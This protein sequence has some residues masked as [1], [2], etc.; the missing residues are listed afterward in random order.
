MEKRR[1]EKEKI[2]ISVVI[3]VFNEEG[4]LEELFLRL[5]ETL[6]SIGSIYE[7]IFVD[8]G[9]RDNS[10][11][12]L[13]ELSRKEKAVRV[14]TFRKNFRKSAALA[15]G[16]GKARGKI[17][18]TL[19]ADLQNLPE[20]IPKM[21]ARLEE[22]YD[23]ISGWRINRRDPLSKIIP[24][25]IF[26]KITSLL[27]GIKIHDFNCGFKCY[28]REVIKEIE[29]YGELHRY[30]PVLANRKGFLVGEAKVEH[31][32]RKSG[33]S[34]YRTERFLRGFWDLLTVLFLTRYAKRPLHLFGL[35]GLLSFFSGFAVNA[36]LAFIWFQG[37]YIGGRPLLILGM[38][39]MIM[40]IQFISMG[41][42][43]ELIISKRETAD[44]YTS[45]NRQ[46][47]ADED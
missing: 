20:D 36:Y 25:K 18:I 19:D 47:E 13:E 15:A 37:A 4:S 38:L 28:R 5:Q 39:L 9:S 7:I 17:L 29:L 12:I 6:N 3:P 34:T 41:F 35:L 22:G 10:F 43:G 42:L 45:Q 40:G 44:N 26:N 14:I 11:H 21:V 23:L 31:H 1:I 2:E 46:K 33:K 30:I 24:S 27:T 16:F 32:P 8:D